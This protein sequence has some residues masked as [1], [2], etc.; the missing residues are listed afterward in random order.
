MFAINSVS[1]ALEQRC[2]LS[3]HILITL[4]ENRFDCAMFVAVR[5]ALYKVHVIVILFVAFSELLHLD[6]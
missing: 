4:I 3:H 5:R 6:A 2:L 1:F